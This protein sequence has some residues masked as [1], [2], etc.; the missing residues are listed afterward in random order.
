MLYLLGAVAGYA[1][2]MAFQ[3]YRRELSEAYRTVRD[4]PCLWLVV[5]VFESAR[6][7]AAMVMAIATDEVTPGGFFLAGSWSE[8]P[9]AADLWRPAFRE[10]AGGFIGIATSPVQARPI[11]VLF[12]VALLANAGGG[13]RTLWAPRS[14]GRRLFA[15]LATAA[16]LMHLFWCARAWIVGD[17]AGAPVFSSPVLGAGGRLFEAGVAVA[18]QVWL[19]LWLISARRRGFL[20]VPL[21]EALE[22]TRALGWLIF[23]YWLAGEG[24]R[25]FGPERLGF[26]GLP[27]L[28][29]AVLG[30][31][32]AQV[33]AIGGE[34]SYLASLRRRGWW[35]LAHP[36]R[37]FWWVAV[38]GVHLVMVHL[39]GLGMGGAV[40]EI[41]WARWIWGVFFAF[42][43]GSV[44]V[45]LLGAFVV[46]VEES[47]RPTR[48]SSRSRRRNKNTAE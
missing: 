2:L 23:A 37:T 29:V 9:L 4:F 6:L 41:P 28:A 12:A 45:W 18:V 47:H 46:L 8:I 16:A 39:C 10:A 48:T 17:P 14:F 15:I 30:I 1:A 26:I 7:T 24:A 11:S 33:R 5:G 19:V 21:V 3:P 13:L 40:E 31:L 38:A 43:K 27:V 32:P 25:L 20:E 22:R 42:L 34:A 36:E 35:M 44:I